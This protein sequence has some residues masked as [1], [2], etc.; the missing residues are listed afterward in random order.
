[1]HKFQYDC[2]GDYYLHSFFCIK[3]YYFMYCP[4]YMILMVAYVIKAY[5]SIFWD[6]NLL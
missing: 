3:Y 6:G 4:L 1:M 5:K 2:V